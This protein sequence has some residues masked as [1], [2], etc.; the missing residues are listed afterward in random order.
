MVPTMLPAFDAMQSLPDGCHQE[1]PQDG[2][3]TT[4]S[5]VPAVRPALVAFGA[6]HSGQPR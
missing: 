3:K 1:Q 5:L 6:S 4:S 2:H